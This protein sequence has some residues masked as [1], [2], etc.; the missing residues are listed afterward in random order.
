MKG[1]GRK[2]DAT[3]G[4]NHNAFAIQYH[5]I[6]TFFHKH[7]LIKIMQLSPAHPIGEI[8]VIDTV[9]SIH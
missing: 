5:V 9:Q 6:K 1:V 8:K 7:Q 3:A 2:H 4:R